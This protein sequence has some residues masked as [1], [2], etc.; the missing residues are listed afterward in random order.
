MGRFATSTDASDKWLQPVAVPSSKGGVFGTVIELLE[1]LPGWEV[2]S[3]DE[4]S[5]TV[6]VSKANGFLG[7]T[8]KI[9]IT[10]SGPDGI[11]SSETNVTSESDGMIS[12]DKSNVSTFCRKLWMRVT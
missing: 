5:C 6:H 1:D 10:V 11:P 7:G 9:S 4:E 3:C 2:Q 12:R 8:S